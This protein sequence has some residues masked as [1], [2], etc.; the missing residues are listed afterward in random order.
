M[1]LP[2]VNVFSNPYEVWATRDATQQE[3]LD[4][5]RKHGFFCSTVKDRLITTIANHVDAA[6]YMAKYGADNGLENFINSFLYN[7]PDYKLFRKL[8][9]SKTP[10]VLFDYQQKYPCYII[11]N[12]DKEINDIGNTLSDGQYLFHG[13]LWCNAISN[14]VVLISPFSTSFCPQVALR[15][16][17]WRG[18]AYDAGQI[19]LFVLRSVNSRT[20]VFC[21]PIKGTK[22]GSEKEVIFASGT[23]LFLRNRML[24]NNSYTVRKYGFPNKNVPIYVVEIDI[25]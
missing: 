12:V 2:I 25:T 20:N 7:S 8:M 3:M 17:E 21:F 13:G 11:A 24:I 23:K 1:N 14:T 18:K 9:P 16:A 5:Y 4:H 6:S 10:Q 19:D 15:N 22:M